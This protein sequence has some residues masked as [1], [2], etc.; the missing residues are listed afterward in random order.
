LQSTH[1]SMGRRWRTNFGPKG[2]SATFSWAAT[3]SGARKSHDEASDWYISKIASA[4]WPAAINALAASRNGI[5]DTHQTRSSPS[6]RTSYR[7]ALRGAG[8]MM[9]VSV[10]VQSGG[11]FSRVVSWWDTLGRKPNDPVE[12]LNVPPNSKSLFSLGWGIPPLGTISSST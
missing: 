1:P 12:D 5:L 11:L 4:S 8:V 3:R 7:P 9:S 2:V 6:R 10:E